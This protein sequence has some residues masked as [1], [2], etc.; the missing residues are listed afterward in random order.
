MKK[1]GRYE[2]D[3]VGYVMVLPYI[4]FFLIFVG[5]PLIFSFILVFHK[6]NIISPMKFAG[7]Y[8]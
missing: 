8:N 6:W 4:I 2:T 3:R 7:L 1:L 5:Y